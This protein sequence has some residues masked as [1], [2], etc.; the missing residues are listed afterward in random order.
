MSTKT[1][2]I[3]GVGFYWLSH[4]VSIA[5]AFVVTPIIIHGLG[6]EGYGLW[7]IV[8]S[9]TNYYALTNLGTRKATVKYVAQY[10]AVGDRKAVDQIV[11]SS[12]AFNAVLVIPVMMLG[13]IVALVLPSL[14]DIS[15]QYVVVF[16]WVI[17]LSAVKVVI[18]L[19]GN[20]FSAVLVAS[21]RFDLENIVIV[22][23]YVLTGVLSVLVIKLG[24]DLLGLAFAALI[25]GIVIGVVRYRLARRCHPEI[26]ISP[27][28]ADREKFWDLIKFGSVNLVRGVVRRVSESLPPILIGVI[29]GPAMITFYALSELLTRKVSAL[30]NGVA[31]V[32]MPV[33]SQ[34]DA[35][36]RTAQLKFMYL[37][38][39]RTLLAITICIAALF[40]IFGGRLIDFWIGDG[41][42]ATAYPVLLLLSLALVIQVPSN[43]PRSM[44]TGSGRVSFLA[45]IAV[46][47]LVLLAILCVVLTRSIGLPGAALA[48]LISSFVTGG[49]LI[50]IYASKQF[51]VSIREYFGSIIGRA[52]VAAAPSIV[53]AIMLDYYLPINNLVTLAAVF[54][55]VGAACSGCVFLLCFN[56]KLQADVWNALN[57]LAAIKK[58]AT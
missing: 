42:S 6:N 53:I 31:L 26:T 20:V 19:M 48:F 35:Q 46:V 34:L 23:N 27:R 18:S 56:Q 7:V 57:P 32:V 22:I 28:N 52:V 43:C 44:L 17:V 50:P 2:A 14:V 30:V 3:R 13:V 15:P 1:R 41:Y 58:T 29:L 11:T 47:E 9:I 45:K 24:Y 54:V 8:I 4:F 10:D 12:V 33:A 21:K 51:G 5:I 55:G 37:T 25:V 49:L 39:N 40:I 16:Q 38:T 36:K